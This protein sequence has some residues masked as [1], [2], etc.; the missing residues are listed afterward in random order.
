MAGLSRMLP[1]VMNLLHDTSLGRTTQERQ[2]KIPQERSA[3]VGM[4]TD[5]QCF[6]VE[7]LLEDLRSCP[8][9]ASGTGSFEDSHLSR[10]I[11]LPTG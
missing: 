5:M 1:G 2:S 11:I 9:G 4:Q 8:A 7:E 3:L 6:S 10:L